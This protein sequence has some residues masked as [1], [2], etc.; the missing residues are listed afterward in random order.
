M[1]SR[2]TIVCFFISTF[3]II[4][5]QKQF[6]VKKKVFLFLYFFIFPILTYQYIIYKN[7]NNSQNGIIYSDT[8]KITRVLGVKTD[9]GRTEIWTSLFHAYNPKKIFGYG[10]QADRRLIGWEGEKA[11]YNNASNAFVYSFVCGGYFGFVIF[12]LI[13]IR[14]IHYI[15]KSFYIKKL[16]NN[17][18]LW[19]AQ[20]SFIYLIFFLIREFIENSFALFS[21]DFLV[22]IISLSIID[23]FLKKRV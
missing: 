6:L 10:P 12:L 16:F 14:I 1:Q 3:L 21:I 20:L 8:F 4:F 13:N 18:N 7:L 5:L 23:N 11:Y 19:T 2:G 17:S 15:Y 22:L 9:S